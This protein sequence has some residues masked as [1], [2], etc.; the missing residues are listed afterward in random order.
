MKIIDTFLFFNE[1]DL[2]EIRL[3]ELYPYVNYFVI[4]EATHTFSG[5]KKP[6][7]YQENKEYFSKYND[8]I[9]HNVIEPPSVEVLDLIGSTYHTNIKCHQM[10]AYQKDSIKNIL[11]TICDNE[12]V[13][14]WS[15]VDELPNPEV[16]QHLNDFYDD[17]VIYNFAQEYCMCY[18]NLVEKSGIFR[19]QT[20]DF[21]YSVYPRWIGT[22][23]FSYKML[24]KYTLTQM[25]QQLPTEHNSRIFPGGWHW[26]YV[27]SNGLSVE[28]RVLTKIESA[29]HQE[30]NNSYTRNNILTNIKNN[31]DPLGRGGNYE[32]VSINDYPKTI[33]DNINKYSYLIK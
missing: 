19:S 25:R 29:A 32:V 11:E 12:D 15:D 8:K 1:L 16:I 18:L 17:N 4:N 3:N 14:V 6:L 2:L 20:P 27:G 10:D 28:N 30:H 31:K 33:V 13:I 24:N 21:D 7:F 23:I 22:K 26:S 5:I 9:I